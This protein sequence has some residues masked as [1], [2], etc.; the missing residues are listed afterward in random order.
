VRLQTPKLLPGALG[1]A[2]GFR[3]SQGESF[4]QFELE[5]RAGWMWR[6][7]PWR[8]QLGVGP[9][10]GLVL[11]IQDNLPDLSRRIGVAPYFGGA[12]EGR[13]RLAGALSLTL[14]AGAGALVVKKVSGNVGRFPRGRLR[15]ARVRRVLS[16]LLQLEL[17]AEHV[18]WVASGLGVPPVDREAI[19]ARA[20]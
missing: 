2:V 16:Q 7:S 3:V 4:S 9:E 18:D 20:F 19:G 1:L 8:L 12:A 10:L 14:G 6:W 17:V 11:V 13:I 15:R 5:G